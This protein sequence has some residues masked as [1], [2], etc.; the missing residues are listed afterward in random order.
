[1]IKC[2]GSPSGGRVTAL[3]ELSGPD[4]D[5]DEQHKAS[6][7]LKHVTQAAKR[8]WADNKIENGDV[9]EVAAW[10]HGRRM[11][12][13][14]ALKRA[15]GQLTFDPTEMAEVLAAR[16]FTRDEGA[17]EPYQHDAPPPPQDTHQ[18][19]PLTEDELERYLTDTSNKSAP[20]ESGV[21]WHILKRDGNSP[22]ATSPHY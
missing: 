2:F 20:G 8:K 3:R 13:I 9:W 12:N 21:S 7:H 18:F 14:H 1:M 19:E 22:D 10:R 16:F 5:V 4:G 17:I 11:G 15:D 6:K